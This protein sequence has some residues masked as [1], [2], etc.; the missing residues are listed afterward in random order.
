MITLMFLWLIIL[1][2]SLYMI[3]ARVYCEDTNTMPWMPIGFSCPVLCASIRNAIERLIMTDYNKSV[4]EQLGHKNINK[5]IFKDDFVNEDIIYI[6]VHGL[7]QNS[8]RDKDD[9]KEPFQNDISSNVNSHSHIRNNR[10]FKT[11]QNKKDTSSPNKSNEKINDI[12]SED[13]KKNKTTKKCW[14]L[15]K[16]KPNQLIGKIVRKECSR[17]SNF[18]AK[19]L[20]IMTNVLNEYA[21]TRFKFT[22]EMT[23]IL[24]DNIF[25]QNTDLRNNI[26]DVN[27]LLKYLRKSVDLHKS[28]SNVITLKSTH[29]LT[30]SLPGCFCKAGYVES[31]G[32]CVKPSDCVEDA[33]YKKYLKRIIV[34]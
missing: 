19:F 6:T 17:R 13:F 2:Q 11:L 4:Q 5:K 16:F 20:S 31:S 27:K 23:E 8:I 25:G 26:F 10:I 12:Y 18:D 15:V 24:L 34:I 29:C 14:H 21:N 30:I 32:Q 28:H 3:E 1:R 22:N 33:Y 7:R 9:I